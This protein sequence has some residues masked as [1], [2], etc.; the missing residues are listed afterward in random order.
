MTGQIV[1]LEDIVWLFCRQQTGIVICIGQFVRQAY[2]K[3]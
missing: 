2:T 1:S 3:L